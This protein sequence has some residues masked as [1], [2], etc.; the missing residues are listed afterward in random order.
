HFSDKRTV[1]FAEMPIKNRTRIAIYSL[2]LI[3]SLLH[4]CSSRST[5]PVLLKGAGATA[6]YLVYSKWVDAYKEDPKLRLQYEA[7]GSGAGIQSLKAQAVDFA[8]SDMPLSD[9][10]MDA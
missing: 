1:D 3:T 7:N 9:D 8:A 10:E 2:V 4:G 6:P 5:G